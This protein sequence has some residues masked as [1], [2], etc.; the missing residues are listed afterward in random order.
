VPG[1]AHKLQVFAIDAED[2]GSEAV[3]VTSDVVPAPRTLPTSNGNLTSPAG[4]RPGVA[5]TVPT[6]G[7]YTII[8]S[9]Y[10]PN[11]QVSVLIY[12]EPQ[13][14]T[15]VMTDGGG[16][17]TVEVTVPEGLAL[18]EHTLVAAGLDPNGVMRYLTLPI[19]VTA[20]GPRLADTGADVT[21]P[22]VGGLAA[23]VVGAGLL[24]AARRRPQTVSATSGTD[25]TD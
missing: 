10:A 20:S 14:L 19:T 25:L 23:V 8:G 12:S 5:T 3:T 11:T 15:T 4:F 16:S 6:G 1:V 22:A 21:A 9:G 18:G 7:K 17:F 13:I 2:N 24:V